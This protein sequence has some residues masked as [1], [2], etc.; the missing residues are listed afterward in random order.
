MIRN[1][2]KKFFIN[3]LDKVILMEYNFKNVFYVD[4]YIMK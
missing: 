1:L 2:N 3:F 4:V